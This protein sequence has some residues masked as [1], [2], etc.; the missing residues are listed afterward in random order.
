MGIPMG[1]VQWDGCSV[2][3]GQSRSLPE[4]SETS[5]QW[6]HTPAAERR[7]LAWPH[8]FS[9]NPP[10]PWLRW[11]ALSDEVESTL[12]WMSGLLGSGTG[13]VPPFL[14]MQSGDANAQACLWLPVSRTPP[15]V[16]PFVKTGALMFLPGTRSD[17]ASRTL[18]TWSQL[19]APVFSDFLIK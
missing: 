1:K 4:G 17:S 13:S 12:G 6:G 7:I 2:G 8:V 14:H 15:S 18:G 19:G 9:R 10:R 16:S 5:S 3:G 11:W